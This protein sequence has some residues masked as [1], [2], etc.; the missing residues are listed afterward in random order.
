[1]RRLICSAV[2]L[3]IVLTVTPAPCKS[4]QKVAAFEIDR[5]TVIAFFPHDAK[6]DGKN[7]D[8][9]ESLSYFQLYAASAQRRL[10][11]AAVDLQVIY[12]RSFQI[13]LDAKVTTFRPPK[14]EPGY[15]FAMPGH[16]PRIEYGVMTDTDIVRIAREYFGSA[17]K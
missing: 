14:A 17:M 1:M 2:W 10:Q 16:K 9:N 3:A 12:A 13:V 4:S 8:T 15:Y 7:D 5:P 6:A 11:N